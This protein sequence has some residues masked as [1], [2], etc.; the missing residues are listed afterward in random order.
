VFVG[1]RRLTDDME[2]SLLPIVVVADAQPRPS[3]ILND[4]S[5][6]RHN[7]SRLALARL[8]AGLL[9]KPGNLLKGAAD[10]LD[11]ELNA[12]AILRLA[13]LR[14]FHQRCQLVQTGVQGVKIG[15]HNPQ[16]RRTRAD[17]GLIQVKQF[18]NT[19]ERL[20]WKGHY[21]EVSSFVMRDPAIWRI[22]SFTRMMRLRRIARRQTSG[23]SLRPLLGKRIA[24]RVGERESE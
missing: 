7:L 11:R 13:R 14:Q 15:R 8:G 3:G 4:P 19:A 12:S 18:R 23:R 9:P 2:R 24:F 10:K 16:F 17:R 20:S 22:P 21:W 5:A 1:Q 6:Q